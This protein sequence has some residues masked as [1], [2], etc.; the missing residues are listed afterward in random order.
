MATS[1]RVLFCHRMLSPDNCS[2]RQCQCLSFWRCV[3]RFR[4]AGL[5]GATSR[6]CQ[7]RRRASRRRTRQSRTLARQFRA[8]SIVC[9]GYSFDSLSGFIPHCGWP[10]RFEL[11]QRSLD[12]AAH[13]KIARPRIVLRFLAAV[14]IIALE[15]RGN[16]KSCP[17]FSS[18]ESVDLASIPLRA[19]R[20][21]VRACSP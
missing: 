16:R 21:K 5:V 9:V 17:V 20:Y 18:S 13:P 19:P 8:R 10:G 2:R 12:A 4:S 14:R 1:I 15:Q 6:S 3:C 7:P 11:L